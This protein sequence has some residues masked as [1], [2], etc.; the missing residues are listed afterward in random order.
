MFEL[1]FQFTGIG[2]KN[3]FLNDNK[4]MFMHL[5]FVRRDWCMSHNRIYCSYQSYQYKYSFEMLKDCFE[6]AVLA[7]NDVVTDILESIIDK[8]EKLSLILFGTEIIV[9]TDHVLKS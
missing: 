6:K 8:D 5:P 4:N 9:E 1:Y 3:K 2:K 7:G